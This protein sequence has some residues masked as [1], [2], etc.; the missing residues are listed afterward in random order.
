MDAEE[1]YSRAMQDTLENT[2]G[3]ELAA[4]VFGGTWVEQQHGRPP[5]THQWHLRDGSVRFFASPNLAHCCMELTGSGCEYLIEKET[6]KNVLEAVADRV[7]RID[8]ASDIETDVKPSEFV[9]KKKHER[10]RASGSQHSETGDT[11]YVGSQ[12]SDR[13]ARV[14]RYNSPHPR[15]HLLRVE[16]V[17][18]RSYAKVVAREICKS[19]ASEIARSAGEAF[20]W[21]HPVWQPESA[22]HR[23]ISIVSP[24]RD[25]GRTIFWLTNTAA[26]SFRRL[27]AAGD[28]KDPV[29]FLNRYF[30]LEE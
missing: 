29:E 9:S 27:V 15:A 17:F 25:A 11:E 21:S 10:M 28:I 3:K 14:Y 13:Y 7:T 23:D 5:Y 6:L 16:H 12:K 2:F 19:S 1:L 22:E 20:G 4:Q 26:A 8:I 18:R 24:S 30:L